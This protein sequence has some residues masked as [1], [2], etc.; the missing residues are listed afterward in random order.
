ML[1]HFLFASIIFPGAWPVVA[2][3]HHGLDFILV[4]TAHLPERGTGYSFARLNYLS[5][6]EDETEIEPALLYGAADW[7]AVEI[8][9]HVA[10]E[11]SESLRYES[12]APAVHFRL[13]PRN[14]PTSFGV[15][16][17]YA[18]A[19]G[20]DEDVADLAG[21]FGLERD[22]WMVAANL[23]YEKRSGASGE[24]GYAAG[25]RRTFGEK[26]G[27]GLEVLGS[28]ENDGYSEAMLGY[29]GELSEQFTF[30]AGVGFGIDEGPDHAVH[31]TFIWR[32]R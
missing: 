27:V 28:F 25:A 4:Q 12:A 8:H 30:N 17:E 32:F 19:H 11:G 15:S 20:E 14:S 16:A 31:M 26:H 21:V 7:M 1:R 9:A 23:L 29:Y 13:T 10:K 5:D 2:L 6:T 22:R 3:A 18:F 24:L